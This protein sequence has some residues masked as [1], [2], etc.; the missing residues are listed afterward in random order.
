MLNMI[1]GF[2]FWGE[3]YSTVFSTRNPMKKP[4]KVEIKNTSF[5]ELNLSNE[6]IRPTSIPSYSHVHAEWSDENIFLAKFKGD[7]SARNVKI[8]DKSITHIKLLKRKSESEMWEV[9]KI[10]DFDPDKIFYDLSDKFVEA[11]EIYQYKIIP[12][13]TEDDIH[14][15]TPD[16]EASFTDGKSL[17]P[18]S[19]FASY[20]YAHIFDKENDYHFMYKHAI[21]PYWFKYS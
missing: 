3:P 9:Y 15:I 17:N 13:N 20:N 14:N 7:L 21:P 19:L 2:D 11:E 12:M 1:L 5:N 16:S 8:R 10:I 4:N 18:Q 6:L